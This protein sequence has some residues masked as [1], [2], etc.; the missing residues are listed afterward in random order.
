MPPSESPTWRKVF[1]GV[2]KRIAP[3]LTAVT[4]SPDVHMVVQKLHAAKGAISAPI[5]HATSWGLHLVGLPSRH[6]VRNLTKQLG[7]VQRD[8]L[9]L[10][11]D[12]ADDDRD[13]QES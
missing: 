13:V 9:S 11:R 10:R 8:L 2:E 6:D 12:L 7:E 3:P 5:G 1:D 4:S